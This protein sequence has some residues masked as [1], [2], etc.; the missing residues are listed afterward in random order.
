MRVRLLTL[1]RG[2]DFGTIRQLVE[3]TYLPSGIRTS[4]AQ[5]ELYNGETI[6]VPTTELEVVPETS[7]VVTT[8]VTG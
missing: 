2:G 5:V 4:T 1:E 8:S 3:D 6:R 7:D